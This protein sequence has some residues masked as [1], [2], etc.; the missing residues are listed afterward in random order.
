[1]K[2]CRCWR[3]GERIWLERLDADVFVIFGHSMDVRLS[4]ARN[5]QGARKLNVVDS[6]LE[7]DLN[8]RVRRPPGP[9]ART[10]RVPD[11]RLRHG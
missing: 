1:M 5:R 3:K 8:G 11:R 4:F 9:V 10:R 2:R 7:R 6:I